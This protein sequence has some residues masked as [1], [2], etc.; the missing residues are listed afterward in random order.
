MNF[1]LS[2]FT[3]PIFSLKLV[4]DSEFLLAYTAQR[5]YIVLGEI[6]ECNT[7]FNTL[8]R[9]TDCWVIHPLTYCTDILFHNSCFI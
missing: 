5:T 1:H 2:P 7:W 9:V 4:L 3:F 6:L 8:L